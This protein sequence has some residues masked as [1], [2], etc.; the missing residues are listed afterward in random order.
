MITP[1]VVPSR[2]HFQ[3]SL[4]VSAPNGRTLISPL[5]NSLSHHMNITDLSITL[6]FHNVYISRVHALIGKKR[7]SF[8]AF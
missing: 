2:G 6:Y 3:A 8:S 7:L 5:S 4:G 1:D